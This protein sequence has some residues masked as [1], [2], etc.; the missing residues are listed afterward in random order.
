MLLGVEIGDTLGSRTER[1]TAGDRQRRFGW[2]ADH[3]VS[4]VS[5]SDDTQMTSRL[6]SSQASLGHLDIADAVRRWRDERL[7]GIGGTLLRVLKR[8]PTSEDSDEVWKARATNNAAGNGAIM[9]VPGLIAPHVLTDPSRLWPDL[10]LGSAVT[11]DSLTSNAACVGWAALL[12]ALADPQTRPT[13]PLAVLEVFTKT[14]TPVEGSGSALRSRV[15]GDDFSGTLC[16]FIEQRAVPAFAPYANAQ[17]HRDR[18]Y[19]GAFL[20]E[21]VPTALGIV[22]E[23]INDP[24][25]GILEAVNRTWDNDTI[26]SL[27]AAAFGARYGLDAFDPRWVNRVVSDTHRDAMTPAISSMCR[28]APHI[29]PAL[30]RVQERAELDEGQRNS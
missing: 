5:R 11:H 29:G 15:P 28:F 8:A 6:L 19:S 20:L 26:A 27:V 25:R 7:V 30:R 16:E 23:Y 21:T 9:R 10:L 22:A 24:Q 2:I 3:G 1:M 13:T 14:A 17:D 18:W 4:R 12:I